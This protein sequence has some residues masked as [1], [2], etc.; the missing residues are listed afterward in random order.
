M[1]KAPPL[2]PLPSH[3]L[4]AHN[5]HPVVQMYTRV[6][7][8]SKTHLPTTPACH[9]VV[10][11]LELS[12]GVV[13]CATCAPIVKDVD[14]QGVRQPID[15]QCRRHRRHRCQ[16]RRCER[17]WRRC[18]RGHCV[19]PSARADN[20]RRQGWRDQHPRQVASC[21]RQRQD[22][23]APR[24]GDCKGVSPAV[25]AAVVTVSRR[26]LSILPWAPLHLVCGG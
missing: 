20:A 9:V 23:R 2:P 1:T 13:I 18:T 21:A 12:A 6:S 17:Q 16:Q 15:Q 3:A 11:L 14:G 8:V 5:R 4:A 22:H 10:P 26:D 19:T 24:D 25:G 7:T